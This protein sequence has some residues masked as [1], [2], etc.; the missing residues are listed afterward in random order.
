MGKNSG[1]VIEKGFTL[2]ELLLVITIMSILVLG[3]LGLLNP[4]QQF[5]KANDAQRQQ[6]LNQIRVAIDA[7]YNDTGCYPLSMTF[8]SAFVSPKNSSV[9]YMKKVPQDPTCGTDPTKCYQYLTDTSATCPQWNVLLGALRTYL[10]T[11]SQTY[12]ALETLD[13]ATQGGCLPAYYKSNG[14]NFCLTSGKVD[15]SVVITA[16]NSAVSPTP[17]CAKIYA[18][19]SPSVQL[20]LGTCNNV[21]TDNFGNGLGN[22][23]GYG[24]CIGNACC[25]NACSN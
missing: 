21:G 7:Y 17:S 3:V 19:E 1:T 25:S 11:K 12:C 20:P 2:I 22:Y 6:D 23:C 24:G 15:C 4:F 10:N 5:S 9:I 18:C 16:A 14:Y 8:G 13:A